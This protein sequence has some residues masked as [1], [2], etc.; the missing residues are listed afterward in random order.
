MTRSEKKKII[1]LIQS[2][3]HNHYPTKTGQRD[4]AREILKSLDKIGY[5]FES[6]SSN[7]TGGGNE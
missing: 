3:I 5:T 7:T 6:D 1:D 4:S 2:H